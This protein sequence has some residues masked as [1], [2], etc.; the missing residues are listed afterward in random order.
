MRFETVESIE[1]S[2]SACSDAMLQNTVMFFEKKDEWGKFPWRF[3]PREKASVG[4]NPWVVGFEATPTGSVVIFISCGGKSFLFS[5]QLAHSSRFCMHF[6]F[7]HGDYV[8]LK[9]DSSH[10]LCEKVCRIRMLIEFANRS[11]NLL[12]KFNTGSIKFL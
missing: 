12:Q 3:V 11:C 10:A 8:T 2:N 9:Q 4:G 1:F 7:R 6:G 5:H